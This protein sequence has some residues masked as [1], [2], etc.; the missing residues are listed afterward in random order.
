MSVFDLI[1]QRTAAVGRWVG[2]SGSK[3]LFVFLCSVVA[4]FVVVGAIIGGVIYVATGGDGGPKDVR[5]GPG[6]VA[7]EHYDWSAA[8]K[9]TKRWTVCEAR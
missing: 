3:E 1:D 9:T 7:V 2:N 8:T 5:C 4:T 6:T